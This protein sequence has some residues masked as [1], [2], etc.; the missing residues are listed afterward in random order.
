MI[1]PPANKSDY[2]QHQ[3][4]LHNVYG[5][6]YTFYCFPDT[7]SDPFGYKVKANREKYGDFCYEYGTWKPINGEEDSN[8][9]DVHATTSGSSSS[10]SASDMGQ[11]LVNFVLDKVGLPYVWRRQRRC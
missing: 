2:I 6:N 5:A 3:T 4:E 10:V 9:T 7:N 11:K 1:S 8:A